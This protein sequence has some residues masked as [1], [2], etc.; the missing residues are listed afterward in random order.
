VARILRRLFHWDSFCGIDLYRV[1]D[2]LPA[3]RVAQNKTLVN[4]LLH[5]GRGGRGVFEFDP[6]DHEEGQG[7]QLTEQK[8]INYMH[9]T[10]LIY[11]LVFSGTLCV[12]G[13]W[14]MAVSLLVGGV[15][16]LLNFRGLDQILRIIFSPDGWFSSSGSAAKGMV[17]LSFFVR[18]GLIVLA[19]GFLAYFDRI[20]LVG[21]LLGLSAA[22]FAIVST[23]LIQFDFL[24]GKSST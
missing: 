12:F 17:Y 8:L 13:V 22:L 19:V 5:I 1:R 6:C 4:D 15:I 9:G 11:V 7:G 20:H 21:M 2:R 10:G 16:S 24:T 23:V 3:G 14:E 18:F